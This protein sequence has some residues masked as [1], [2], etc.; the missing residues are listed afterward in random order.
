M[1]SQTVFSKV[2][3][4]VSLDLIAQVH[5]VRAHSAVVSTLSLYTQPKSQQPHLLPINLLISET[6]PVQCY[7]NIFYTFQYSCLC[8]QTVL[9]KF[10]LNQQNTKTKYEVV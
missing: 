1:Q 7:L 8:R 9:L 2:L 6:Q 5:G 3:P 4:L 10:C